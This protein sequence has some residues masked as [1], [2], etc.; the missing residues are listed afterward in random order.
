MAIT[1]VE[2]R[3]GSLQLSGRQARSHYTLTIRAA[4]YDLDGKATAEIAASTSAS[5]DLKLRPAHNI[6][7]QL[8][9]AEWIDSVS[10]TPA[11]KDALLNCVGCHT[12]E[13]IVRSTHDADEFVQTMKRMAGY[14]NQSLPVRPQKRKA[15]RLLEERVL[16]ARHCFASAP[17]GS[18]R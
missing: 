18:P 6:A 13:R 3:S 14:A 4:G 10:G 7:S 2:R 16:S 15:Q 12:L 9:N 8:S 17:N 11:Q 1:V 5:A